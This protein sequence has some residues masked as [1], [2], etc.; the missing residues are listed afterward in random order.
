[1]N[2]L[3]H[4]QTKQ[5]GDD[6]GHF[7]ATWIRVHLAQIL[8]SFWF[9]LTFVLF[10]LLGPFSAIAVLIGLGSLGNAENRERMTE[11]ASL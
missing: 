9:C 10:L 6:G 3:Q 11:P 1:M 4:Y 2:I 7:Q 8:E 5:S